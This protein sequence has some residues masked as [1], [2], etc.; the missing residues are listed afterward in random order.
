MKAIN[1]INQIGTLNIDEYY[2]LTPDD[3][4]YNI[5]QTLEEINSNVQ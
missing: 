4:L 1:T 5:H 2:G 3:A